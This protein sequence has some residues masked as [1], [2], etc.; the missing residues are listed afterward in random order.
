MELSVKIFSIMSMVEW[1]D[2]S[3]V[4]PEAEAVDRAKQAMKATEG[5]S[6]VD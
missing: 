3:T 4:R 2:L 6:V 1:E 5:V